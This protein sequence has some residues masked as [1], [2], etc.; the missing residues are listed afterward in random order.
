MSDATSEL[1]LVTYVTLCRAS[2]R[3]NT[4]IFTNLSIG[5]FSNNHGNKGFDGGVAAKKTR[6]LDSVLTL[7]ET[8]RNLEAKHGISHRWSQTGKDWRD[9]EKRLAQRE[10]HAAIDHL[11]GLVVARLFELGKMNKAETGIFSGLS[12]QRYTDCSHRL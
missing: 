2:Y 3:Q 7:Q 9:A 10:Y 6:G 12:L 1:Y 4:S 11:E 8:I 5:N